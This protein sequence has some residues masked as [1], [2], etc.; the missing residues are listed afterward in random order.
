PRR[1]FPIQPHRPRVASRTVF[2]FSGFDVMSRSFITRRVLIPT[3][4][5]A[6]LA[7]CAAGCEGESIGG[8]LPTPSD[9]NKLTVPDPEVPEPPATPEERAQAMKLLDKAIPVH[10]G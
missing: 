3:M 1:A 10:G 4:F 9:E 7:I 5:L 2:S 8:K 6:G